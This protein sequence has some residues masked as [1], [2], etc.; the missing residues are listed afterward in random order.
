MNHFYRCKDCLTVMVTPEKIT[1]NQVHKNGVPIIGTCA[2]CEGWIEYL[3]RVERNRLIRTVDMCPCDGRCTSATGPSCDCQ[4]GGEN[5]GTNRS[6]EVDISVP[7]PQFMAHPD[8][9]LKADEYLRIC[10]QFESAWESKYGDVVA[11][12]RAGYISDFSFYLEAMEQWSVYAKACTLRTHTGR[13]KRITEHTA[14]LTK[15]REVAYA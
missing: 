15:A 6:V 2:A 1:C 8:A 10:E 4:C 5:H 13:N 7:I 14:R 12:K 11:R 9:K 3:G